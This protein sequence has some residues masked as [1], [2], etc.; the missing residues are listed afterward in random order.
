MMAQGSQLFADG[1]YEE[2]AVSLEK[3]VHG[4]SRNAE[5]LRLLAEA[6]VALARD[7]EALEVLGKLAR[8][9]GESATIPALLK[10]IL[11]RTADIE[12]SDA[13]RFAE[14]L[15]PK[16]DKKNLLLG[17]LSFELGRLER[18]AE[19][20]EEAIHHN[21]S[22][23]TAYQMLG[24]TRRDQ[25][26]AAEA[27]RAFRNGV[28]IAPKSHDARYDLAEFLFGLRRFDEAEAALREALGLQADSLEARIL[29]GRLLEAKGLPQEAEEAY[30]AAIRH[31]PQSVAACL[32]LGEFCDSRGQY[33]ES[34]KF[35]REAIRRDPVSPHGYLRMAEM[36]AGRGKLEAAA[37]CLEDAAR[38]QPKNPLVLFKL[39][40]LY[41]QAGDKKA[42]KAAFN[43]F[44][45]LNDGA[46]KH[47][48]FLAVM[49]LEKFERAFVEAEKI[50]DQWD[51]SW[52]YARMFRPWAN[53]W[54]SP[55]TD[56]YYESFA[57]KLVNLEGPWAVLYR[58][59]C[60]SHLKRRED[61]LAVLD[62]LKK[63]PAK[64]YGWMRFAAGVERLSVGRYREAVADFRAVLRS[65]PEAWWASCRLAEALLC[66]G[67][68]SGALKEFKKAEA[69]V[70][71]KSVRHNLL[72]WRG[73]ALL[74]VGRYKE[75]L[76][77][78]NN[79]MS[80]GSWLA[81]CWR[82]AAR[83]LMGFHEE[84]RMDLDR[85]IVSGS[86]D[87]EAF[88]WRG[89]LY[90][91][92]GQF[93]KSLADLDSAVELRG[94]FW[95]HLNRALTLAALGK[96]KEMLADVK[97]IPMA[98]LKYGFKR[99]GTRKKEMD[100]TSIVPAL[101]K[102]LESGRGVRRYEEYLSP[103]WMKTGDPTAVCAAVLRKEG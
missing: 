26:R 37:R 93:Q 55:R 41:E 84:A 90:R 7:K 56:E 64:R 70:G 71:H 54:M 35:L 44:L 16:P 77:D 100:G 95:A 91:R 39:G 73:E 42:M 9:D 97:R 49:A 79:A 92:R 23:V 62:R 13:W 5:K 10:T 96:K 66:L 72:A 6:Y 101:E 88:V 21:A 59:L 86:R 40:W 12:N 3:E 78:L 103:I 75:A 8:L 48:R 4:D 98:V 52:E 46:E 61:A 22:L 67:R 43:A 94:G 51:A 11:L 53:H 85:V 81:G 29:L 99:I 28:R 45:D 20:L 31:A 63:A 50:L 27:E 18:A 89:E 1:R 38:R 74:W 76:T 83:M 65:K 47:H 102:I 80:E 69:L 68:T 24:V 15:T 87:A 34:E 60:Y 25:G 57:R 33:E 36:L 14:R 32:R 58:G 17:S 82:G 2:A 19:F 30:R